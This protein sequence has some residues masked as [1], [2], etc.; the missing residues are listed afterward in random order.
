MKTPDE[1]RRPRLAAGGALAR[2][3]QEAGDLI[4]SGEA[5]LETGAEQGVELIQERLPGAIAKGEMLQFVSGD[6]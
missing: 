2:L 3:V 5:A 6:L 4:G 1:V